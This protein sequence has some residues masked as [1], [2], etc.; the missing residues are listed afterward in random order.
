VQVQGNEWNKKKMAGR[1]GQGPAPNFL[2]FSAFEL[3]FQ[4]ADKFVLAQR[5]TDRLNGFCS[6]GKTLGK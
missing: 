4:M 2:P 3:P 6:K 5:V 1:V